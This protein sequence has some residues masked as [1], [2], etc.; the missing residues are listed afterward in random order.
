MRAVLH[1]EFFA[2][3]CPWLT[4]ESPKH[5]IC[6]LPLDV[7]ETAAAVTSS[8]AVVILEGEVEVGSGWK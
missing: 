6:P 5:V 7:A 4:H 3:G 1:S 8:S 2:R